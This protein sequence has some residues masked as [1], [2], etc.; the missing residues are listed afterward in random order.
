[1][2]EQRLVARAKRKRRGLTKPDANRRKAPDL[3]RRGFSPPAEPDVRW[4]GDLTEIPTDEGKLYLAT[5]EDLH[6]RRVVGFALGERHDAELAKA[7]LCMA[8][9][10]RG[11]EVDGVVFHSDQ[12][13]EYTGG[14]FAAACARAGAR[15]AGCASS[16][17][18]TCQASSFPEGAA[19]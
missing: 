2:A 13:G 12:G 4:V 6:S 19:T 9:A 3:L 10:V 7:A 8:I 16:K 1:M 14:V 17:Q 5:V 15:H 11:G 18:Y